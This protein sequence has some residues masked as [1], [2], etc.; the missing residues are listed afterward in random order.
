MKLVFLIL[1]APPHEDDTTMEK[2]RSQIQEAARRGIKLI[3]VTA[4]GIGRETEFLMKFMAMLTNGTYVFITDDSGIGDA[5]LDP[6]VND[7]E[8]EKLN[9]CLVRLITQYSK[10][11]SCD[12]EIRNEN[13][14]INVYPNPATQFINVKANSV[15][16]K[17]KI[18]SANGMMV[19]SITPS[20][21]ETRIE[22][23]NFV[24]GIYTI[25]IIIGNNIES[26]QIILLK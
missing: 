16:D 1:D 23:G 24:N 20:E 13:I 14:S 9:D 6:V 19:K 10:S 25:S 12:T 7:Y 3:P 15:P 26:K 11:Y 18:Y 4:S 8:V 2:I 21:R 22:M 5:H 17:I